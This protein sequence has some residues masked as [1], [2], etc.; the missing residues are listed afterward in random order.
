MVNSFDR[1]ITSTPVNRTAAEVTSKSDN[2]EPRKKIVCDHWEQMPETTKL[3]SHV[4]NMIGV[5]C[6]RFTVVGYMGSNNNGRALWLVRCACSHFETRR[7][8]SLKNPNNTDDCCQICRHTQ[9]LR[10]EAVRH[11]PGKGSL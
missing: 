10:R 11:G 9:F 4:P 7:T 6:G 2:Y 3:P 8:K 1:I 5:I